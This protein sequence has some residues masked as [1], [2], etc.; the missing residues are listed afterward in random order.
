MDITKPLPFPDGCAEFI[1]AEHTVEHI[2]GPQVLRFFDECHRMLKPGGTL[3]IC[4]PILDRIKDVAHCRDLVLG[5]GHMVVFN[6]GN[7]VTLLQL[8]GFET[9]TETGRKECDG[10]W[11]IIGEAKDSLETLRVE[12]HKAR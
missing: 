4:V 1:L 10:H 3:R 6:H 9:V 8:A 12:A 5:H 2:A 7:L 11:R